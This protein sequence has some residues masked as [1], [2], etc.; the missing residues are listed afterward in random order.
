MANNK[1]AHIRP[2]LKVGKLAKLAFETYFR[3]PDK[4]E[5]K[6]LQDGEY[7]HSVFGTKTT[8]PVLKTVQEIQQ[9][10]NGIHVGE[11]GFYKV[12][13]WAKPVLQFDGVSYRVCNDWHEPSARQPVDNRTS[14][15]VWIRRMGITL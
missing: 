6:N 13:Y 8:M 1:N 9:A 11:A 7:C 10:P 12:H 5:I 15:E 4:T 3:N 2:D 14:L